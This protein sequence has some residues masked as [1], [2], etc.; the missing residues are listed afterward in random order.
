MVQSI[1][2]LRYLKKSQDNFYTFCVGECWDNERTVDDWLCEVNSYTD[3]PVSAFDFPLHY[4]LKNVCDT[5][6]F[7]LT[8]LAAGGNVVDDSPQQ[9][10]TFVDNHDTIRD[11]NNAINNDKLLAYSFILT[12]EGY[13]S[14]F[15]M[16]WYNY[17]LAMSG[18]ANGIAALV[19]AHEK[20]AGG[21][22]QV[23]YADDNLYVM[24]RT[25]AGPQPGLVYVLNNLGDAWNGI[26]V[27][28]Q[29][30]NA[31]FQPVSY[32]GQDASRPDAKTTAEDGQADFWAGPRGWAVYAQI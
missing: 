24:Q 6:G 2:E 21:T 9:A 20:Y 23:L 8:N 27:Q 14:V 32:G 22:T 11:P 26:T 12:H 17:N 30:P 28:T 31:Q 16:D 10:V 19:A 1:A 3:N 5:Y 25:G 4:Q 18:T 13:P 15:W 29:W 7:S